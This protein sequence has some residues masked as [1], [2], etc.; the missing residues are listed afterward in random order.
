MAAKTY[1]FS[2]ESDNGAFFFEWTKGDNHKKFVKL[3]HLQ[4]ALFFDELLQEAGYELI[5]GEND[6]N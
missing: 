1:K 6:G 2:K 4:Q 5:E 3:Q